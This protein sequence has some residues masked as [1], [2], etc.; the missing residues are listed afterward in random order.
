MG[1][2][3]VFAGIGAFAAYYKGLA[4]VGPTKTGMTQ[5]F[6]A[7]T[8]ALFDWLVFRGPF[9][10]MQAVGMAVVIAGTLVASGRLVVESRK[11]KVEN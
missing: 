6:I 3:V 9:V 1:Y 8:A 11:S 5:F 7:P 10:A 4:D 2:L